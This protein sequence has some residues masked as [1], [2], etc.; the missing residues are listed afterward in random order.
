M[1]LFNLINY[2]P[3]LLGNNSLATELPSNPIGELI[4]ILFW[5]GRCLLVLAGGCIGLI[6]IIK[7]KSEENPKDT[8]EGIAVI[9]IAGVLFAATFAVQAVFK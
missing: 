8:T 2:A 1:N 6:K 5:A 4:G 3:Y 7:G 9:I